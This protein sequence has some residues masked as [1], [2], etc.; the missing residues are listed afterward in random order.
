MAIP[1]FSG[2]NVLTVPLPASRDVDSR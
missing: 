2:S 1:M